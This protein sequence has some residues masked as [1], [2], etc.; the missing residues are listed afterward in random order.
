MGIFNEHSEQDAASS[1][2]PQGPPGDMG[3]PGQ[4]GDTG[5]QGPKGDAGA[6]G[7]KGDAGA[8]GLKGDIG[9][10]GPKGNAGAQGPPGPQ[11]P[12]GDSLD[13]DYLELDGSNTM[14]GNLNMG[15]KIITQHGI[16]SQPTDLV[17][18]SYIDTELLAKPNINDTMIL[19]GT[20]AMNG[21]I[22]M[23]LHRI[24]NTARPINP[25][26]V[27]TKAYCDTQLSS[28]L[29]IS[30]GTMTGDLDIGGRTIKNA[31]VDGYLTE[32]EVH[33]LIGESHVTPSTDGNNIFDFLM[34]D[35]ELTTGVSRALVVDIINHENSPHQFNKKAVKIILNEETPTHFRSTIQ[36]ELGSHLPT[37][38]GEYT[39]VCE[40]MSDGPGLKSLYSQSISLLVKKQATKKFPSDNYLK[41]ITQFEKAYDAS[42]NISFV[43]ECDSKPGVSV[44]TTYLVVYGV[45]GLSSSVDPNVYD[46][47]YLVD[48]GKM[49]MKVDL[50]LNGHNLL[51]TPTPKQQ[52]LING[53]YKKN[54]DATY[55]LFSGEQK[56][57]VPLHCRILKVGL[58]II[59]DLQTYPPIFII[60]NNSVG[61]G[62]SAKYQKYDLNVILVEGNVFHVTIYDS[63]QR[64]PPINSCLVTVLLE[65]LNF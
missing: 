65:T 40:A 50:D 26:D 62:V 47:P 23:A 7:P 52:F 51:N 63:K 57:L 27:S 61:R 22:S 35:K 54:M 5:A 19:D 31:T 3:P 38:W 15:G 60:A 18:R 1:K 36:F 46:S 17:N 39:L 33:T 34:K 12:Q 49:L 9:A 2:A 28:K 6:Q 56:V 24:I 48:N 53:V 21:N 20:Q 25:N 45:E 16:G 10:Q 44:Y 11:G 8:Q 42:P 55:T 59:D 64:A 14:T 43:I 30:G 4:K 58:S 32:S 41:C 13:D 37:Q 29:D